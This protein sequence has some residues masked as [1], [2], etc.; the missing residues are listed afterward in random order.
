MTRTTDRC[1]ERK[2][3]HFKCIESLVLQSADVSDGMPADSESS[4]VLT[5]VDNAGVVENVT[6]VANPI[7]SSSATSNTSLEK[8]LSRPTLVDTRTWSTAAPVGDLGA[9]IEPWFLFLNNAV[10]KNKLTNYAF[11]RAKLCMKIVV[12]ASPFHFGLLRVAYEPNVNTANTG[13]RVSKLRT[14]TVSTLP[15]AITLSQLPGTWIYPADNS[16]GEVH[17]PFFRQSNWLKLNSAALTQTMGT[18]RYFIT[19][20]LGVA[21]ATASTTLTMDTFAW[22]EDVE[23]S[24]S[25]AELT[26]QARDEYDGPISK[27]ASALASLSRQVESFPVIGKFARAT[28][29]GASAIAGVASLFGFTNTPIIDGMPAR[30]PLPGPQ[31]ASAEIS[32]PIQKLVLDPKQELSVDPTLHGLPADDELIISNIVSRESVLTTTGWA[33]TDIIG[34][35]IFNAN[36]SPMLFGAV[37]ILNGALVSQARRVYHTPMSYVGMMFTH[38]RGDIIFEVDVV[39]TKFHKGRLKIAWDPLGSGGSTALAENT[40]FTTILDIGET[41]K[42]TFRVPYHQANAWLRTRGISRDNWSPGNSLPVNDLF[43]NGLLVISVFTPLISPVTP[44]NITV[45]ISV[46][47]APNLEYANPRSCLGESTILPPPSFFSVQAKDEV[48]IVSTSQDFG[49][50][51]DQHPERYA[52]NFGQRVVSLRNVLHRMSLYDNSTPFSNAATKFVWY[53]KSYSRLPPMY[54]YDPAGLSSANN[55]LTGV[56]TSTFNYVPTHPLTY[57]SMMFGAFRGG[58]NY[59]AN[60]SG[61]SFPYVGDVRVQRITDNSLSASRR[62]RAIAAQNTGTLSSAT[63]R[64]IN[65]PIAHGT[66]GMAFTNTQTN[67]CVTWNAPHQSCLN[68]NFSDPTY[69]IAGN[70][71][72]ESD[73]ECTLMEV[74]FKQTTAGTVSDQA[75]IVSY[76]GAGVDYT[77]LW[78][79]CCPTL[80][81]YA[82]N[83]TTP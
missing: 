72:D 77:C 28:T 52:L 74:L 2:S 51:G 76:A 1:L 21:S 20:P 44:Q 23:L 3:A 26:L 78:W 24:G 11:I 80:D 14:N 71:S 69:A 9:S 56:G 37:D 54:G 36:V 18:L 38:W 22:L 64:F 29:I 8:F 65:T 30:I 13:N 15:Y 39:C 27:P 66:A 50:T 35:V 33:T 5:F 34:T 67:G 70:S 49:D 59:T 31:L 17:V 41:N 12:N 60:I 53:G 81:Y 61:D 57:V 58:V 19:S 7:A 25:T 68:F 4:E 83:P 42:A 10:I 40:V 73:L 79:L 6:Y 63:I 16:G 45:K 47:G 43:D 75:T 46:K 62:G 48:E 55:I 32:A 82:S